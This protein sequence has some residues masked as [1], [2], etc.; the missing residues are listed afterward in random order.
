MSAMTSR[1]RMDGAEEPIPKRSPLLSSLEN[2]IAKS[3]SQMRLEL[4][5]LGEEPDRDTE[6]E[7]HRDWV[8]KIQAVQT[9]R[10][11]DIVRFMGKDVCWE[12]FVK[13]I[14]EDL[15][16]SMA[17][18]ESIKFW[19]RA[20]LR[21][22]DKYDS[23]KQL[24]EMSGV[25]VEGTAVRGRRQQRVEKPSEAGPSEA[26]LGAPQTARAPLVGARR[27]DCG[28]DVTETL[29]APAIPLGTEG[30]THIWW[31]DGLA[32]SERFSLCLVIR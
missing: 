28:G 2:F 1:I 11:N 5:A 12:P 31:S 25:A 19:C 22:L 13:G 18:W 16:N 24:L 29:G 26:G 9:G 21:M 20:W 17:D 27:W 32:F 6:Q 10:W 30:T 4:E 3:L 15:E 14:I 7:E 23:G 8:S